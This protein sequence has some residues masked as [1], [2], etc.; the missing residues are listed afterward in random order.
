MIKA[1]EEDSSKLHNVF[2][3]KIE[4]DI[5]ED[6]RSNGDDFEDDDEVQIKEQIKKRQ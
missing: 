2:Y 5:D 1:V 6:K 4:E 3:D